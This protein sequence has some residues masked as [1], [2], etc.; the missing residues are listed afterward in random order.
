MNPGEMPKEK[1]TLSGAPSLRPFIIIGLSSQIFIKNIIEP[2]KSAETTAAE[3]TATTA[4]AS[5]K[6][7]AGT[8]NAPASG[9]FSGSGTSASCGRTLSVRRLALSGN[10]EPILEGEQKVLR[11]F[12][13]PGVG[14]I[15]FRGR[16]GI[17]ILI[18]ENIV[19]LEYDGALLPA[20]IIL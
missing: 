6:T 5:A 18:L 12:V 13:A 2:S 19:H 15:G 10:R 20:K 14:D 9:A 17:D 16:V 3:T 4:A 7:S 11:D 8:T 1:G